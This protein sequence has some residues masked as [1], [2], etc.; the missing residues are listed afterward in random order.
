MKYEKEKLKKIVEESLSIADVCRKLNIRPIGGNYKTIKKYIKIYEI[1]NSHFTG[2]GWNVG[3]RF[4]PFCKKYTLKEIMVKNSTYTDS[5]KLKQRL[6]E[7]NIL[8]YKCNEC[9]LTD[10]EGKYI[11]LHLDHINGNNMDNRKNNLRLLCPN[12]HSQTETYC[13]KKKATSKKSDYKEKIYRKYSKQIKINIK[14][15][16]IK[17]YKVNKEKYCSCGKEITKMAVQCLEC[18]HK[19]QRK[20]KNR[21]TKEQLLKDI[22]ETSYSAT[23]RKYGVSDNT[24]R[25]WLRH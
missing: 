18:L 22:K 8:E 15:L 24:I 20:I 1:D 4:K 6:I 12:C 9:G 19:K 25:K 3:K 14:K 11:S 7:E 21:P 2:Q 10:W 13:G 23:G 17:K 5:N 16:N